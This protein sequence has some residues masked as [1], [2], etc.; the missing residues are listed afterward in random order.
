MGRER[1]GWRGKVKEGKRKGRGG[2]GQKGEGRGKGEGC[3]TT[4]QQLC[5]YQRGETLHLTVLQAGK[6]Q[7]ERN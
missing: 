6:S 2:E 5:L 1:E 4:E 7:R 3:L